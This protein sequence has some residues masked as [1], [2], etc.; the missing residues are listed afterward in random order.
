[1]SPGR[2]A[3]LALLSSMIWSSCGSIMFRREAGKHSFSSSG[4]ARDRPTDE[5]YSCSLFVLLPS[6]C[7]SRTLTTSRISCKPFAFLFDISSVRSCF[8]CFT[9]NIQSLR[10]LWFDYCSLSDLVS[11]SSS[12]PPFPLTRHYLAPRIRTSSVA[13]PETIECIPWV[14]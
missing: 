3:A 2:S 5:Q 6:P 1:M 13:Y 4:H 11:S 10:V 8:A 12:F 9:T 7:L 14:I